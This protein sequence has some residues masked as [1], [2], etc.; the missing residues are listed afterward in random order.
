MHGRTFSLSG[1]A[2]LSLALLDM[3]VELGRPC[4]SKMVLDAT[5]SVCCTGF[6]PQEALRV[7]FNL[8][9][10]VRGGFMLRSSC[11][12]TCHAKPFS[13]RFFTSEYFIHDMISEIPFFLPLSS[14]FYQIF[15]HATWP[16]Q[17]AAT[18]AMYRAYCELLTTWR[19]RGF[20]R[21]TSPFWWHSRHVCLSEEVISR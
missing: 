15:R 12:G 7:Y 17:H 6:L 5:L 3:L 11:W 16:L 4:L 1:S 9:P 21:T 13:C 10:Q 18:V 14:G 19:T 8:M 20:P 2:R